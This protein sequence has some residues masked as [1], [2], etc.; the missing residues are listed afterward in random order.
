MGWEEEDSCLGS[1]LFPFCSR[2]RLLLKATLAL[3]E[4]VVEAVVEAVLSYNGFSTV[5][6]FRI[7]K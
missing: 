1:S 6:F 4:T 7:S 5:G 2:F 3:A